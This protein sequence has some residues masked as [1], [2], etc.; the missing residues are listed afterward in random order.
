MRI[1]VLL[2]ITV[3]VTSVIVLGTSALLDIHWIQINLVRKIVVVILMILEAYSGWLIL[4]KILTIK[5]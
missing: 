3:I 5:Q 1:L 4:K 2:V